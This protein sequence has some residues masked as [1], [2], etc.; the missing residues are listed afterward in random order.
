MGNKIEKI[1]VSHENKEFKLI[2]V[3]REKTLEEYSSY[4]YTNE[5]L[6]RIYQKL[7]RSLQLENFKEFVNMPADSDIVSELQKKGLISF[8]PNNLD[9]ELK[10]LRETKKE[11]NGIKNLKIRKTALGIIAFGVTLA[12]GVGIGNFTNK[13]NSE[14]EADSKYPNVGFESSTDEEQFSAMEAET[15][16]LTEIEPEITPTPTPVVTPTPLPINYQQPSEEFLQEVNYDGVTSLHENE[17][18]LVMD[19]YVSLSYI[20]P[21]EIGNHI[22]N[23][24][25]NSLTQDPI[26]INFG[27]FFEENSKDKAFVDYFNKYRNEIIYR[28][29]ETKNLDYASNYIY[30]GNYEIV[31]CIA[32][33]GPIQVMING[34]PEYVFFDDLS[35]QAKETVLQITNG[36]YTAFSRRGEN[37]VEY[38]GQNYD[39]N[40]IGEIIVNKYNELQDNKITK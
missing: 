39:Q 29:Y 24:D 20:N 4:D 40:A 13:K 35:L 28:A 7:I 34:N 27:S 23:P 36:I 6:K 32:N 22:Q 14:K 31:R 19:N 3:A 26:Y 25:A 12:I 38:D 5:E 37:F 17:E 21:Q 11:K 1:I 15:E 2:V 9:E 8:N 30:W 10:E 33:N 16:T 18:G